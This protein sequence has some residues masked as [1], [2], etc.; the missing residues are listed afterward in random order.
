LSL[1]LLFVV[2]IGVLHVDISISI[3]IFMSSALWHPCRRHWHCRCPID[4]WRLR[5]ALRLPVGCRIGISR[6]VLV[7]RRNRLWSISLLAAGRWRFHVWR[8]LLIHGD[9]G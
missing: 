7:R 6:S 8:P 9:I 1:L 3:S 2:G 4:E 5:V